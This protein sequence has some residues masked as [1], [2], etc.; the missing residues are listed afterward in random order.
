MPPPFDFSSGSKT[1]TYT[2]P[3]YGVPAIG[4]SA[5]NMATG[6]FY[7]ITS[8]TKTGFT[9]TFYNSSGTAQN[10]TFDYVAK[11]FGLKS[12]S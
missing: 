2:N 6:D 7:A 11:G 12:A 9:I 3:F 8:K 4:I 10:R 1:I 5:Q